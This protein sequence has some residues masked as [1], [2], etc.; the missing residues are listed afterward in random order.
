VPETPDLCRQV[1]KV[2][3][4][5]QLA[6]SRAV[7]LEQ[8]TKELQANLEYLQKKKQQSRSQLQYS[9]VLQVQEAQN[10]IL[11]YKEAAQEEAVQYNQQRCQQVPPTYSSCYIQG[12]TIR[13]YRNIQTS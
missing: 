9:S 8:E 7:L 3:K 13:Q 5:C 12:H 6:I 11:V 2:I 10:L 1:R 4:R